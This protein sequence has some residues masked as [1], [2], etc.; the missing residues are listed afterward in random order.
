MLFNI[1]E[2]TTFSILDSDGNWYKI[3]LIDG[4]QGWIPRELC[5]EV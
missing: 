1:H 2:G 5:G 4:K 3:E